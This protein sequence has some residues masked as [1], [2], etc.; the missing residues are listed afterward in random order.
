MVFPLF[1][2]S[3]RSDQVCESLLHITGSRTMVRK[4][5]VRI[6]RPETEFAGKIANGLILFVLF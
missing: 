6:L 2:G 3:R 4:P 1:P 5:F